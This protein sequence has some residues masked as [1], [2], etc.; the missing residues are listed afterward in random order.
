MV[1]FEILSPGT[2]R[3]DRIAKLREYQATQSI[4]R[5]VIL[6]QDCVAATIVIRSGAD[7]TDHALTEGVDLSLAEI[8]ADVAPAIGGVEAVS[9]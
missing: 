7:W 4:L 9:A 1:V 3:T 6:E 8:Y 5:Y 2:S